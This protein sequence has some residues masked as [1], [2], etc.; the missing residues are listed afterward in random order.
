MYECRGAQTTAMDGGR[1]S[2]AGSGDRERRR[3]QL[4]ESARTTAPNSPCPENT[5]QLTKRLLDLADDALCVGGKRMRAALFSGDLELRKALAPVLLRRGNAILQSF[6]QLVPAYRLAQGRA[7]VKLVS[8]F[9]QRLLEAFFHLIEL[10][11]TYFRRSPK[12]RGGAAGKSVIF[13]L[14]EHHGRVYTK[15]VQSVTAVELMCRIKGQIRIGLANLVTWVALPVNT[16]P[17]TSWP[18][19]S[20]RTPYP[21][22]IH[23]K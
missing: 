16:L 4:P 13:G 19:N 8:R 6:Y 22:Q 21:R 9:Y 20:G 3:E 18:A 23:S 17:D 10:D 14:L 11:E 12:R 1:K 7:D 2:R 15:V 5:L